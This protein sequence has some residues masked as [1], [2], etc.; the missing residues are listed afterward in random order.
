MAQAEHALRGLDVQESYGLRCS[1][2]NR[3]PDVVEELERVFLDERSHLIRELGEL[4]PRKT[5]ERDADEI[6]AVDVSSSASEVLLE[7]DLELC[8]RALVLFGQV[9]V[10]LKVVELTGEDVRDGKEQLYLDDVG[11]VF[12]VYLEHEVEVGQDLFADA[13]VQ[14]Q[15]DEL[16]DLLLGEELGEVL[17]RFLR[18]GDHA[19]QK[20]AV[21]L[22]AVRLELG[23]ESVQ[24]EL[25]L[26][27]DLVCVVWFE[28]F[29]Q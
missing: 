18:H 21:R 5:G 11:Q 7:L 26:V 12:E 8:D 24:D 29:G 22:A 16:V 17:L 3:W 14:Q 1:F 4:E 10:D 13:V 25:G 23:A 2:A 20:V 9:G 27:F 28:D 15:V 6:L 19:R